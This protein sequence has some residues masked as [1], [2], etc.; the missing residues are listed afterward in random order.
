[1][2]VIGELNYDFH[3][4]LFK[5][6]KIVVPLRGGGQRKVRLQVRAE[7]D[8]VTDA[9]LHEVKVTLMDSGR[10][11]VLRGLMYH[12]VEKYGETKKIG[13][14]NVDKD[15]I[16][17]RICVVDVQGFRYIDRLNRLCL[18]IMSDNATTSGEE[19]E[20][21]IEK[22]NGVALVDDYASLRKNGLMSDVTIVCEGERFPVHKLILSARSQVFAAMFSHKDTLEDKHKEVLVEDSDKLTMDLFLTFLYDA[23]LH[24]DLP[25]ESYAELLKAADKYQVTSLIKACTVKLSKKLSTE[26][27]AIQGAILG[28]VYRIPMLKNEAIKVI[29]KSDATTLNS[30]DGY[31]ELRNYPDL[32]VEIIIEMKR[33]CVCLV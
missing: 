1:M 14:D 6:K 18:T 31:L 33:I 2:I 28:S 24:N 25:F 4:S 7:A 29:T 8:S 21:E 15:T 32:L 16:R 22:N 17:W 20:K 27:E 11:E 9:V 5:E 23:T 3:E 19:D 30:M 26:N 13:E 12:D 10:G